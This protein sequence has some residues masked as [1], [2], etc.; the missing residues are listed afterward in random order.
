MVMGCGGRC[1]GGGGGGRCGG[2]GGEAGGRPCQTG[3]LGDS[4]NRY[5]LTHNPAPSPS[6]L[7]Y[8]LPVSPVREDPA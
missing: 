1:G 6:S 8:L 4:H 2:G 5:G 3:R 7:P